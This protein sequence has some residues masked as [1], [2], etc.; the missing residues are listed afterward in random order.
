MQ[1]TH[2]L[3]NNNNISN[4]KYLSEKNNV[5]IA[6]PNVYKILCEYTSK[7]GWKRVIFDHPEKYYAHITRSIV[8]CFLWIYTKDSLELVNHFYERK[9]KK[10]NFIYDLLVYSDCNTI[11]D[12][13]YNQLIIR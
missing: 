8:S 12:K 7:Y 6:N 9:N 1:I 13:K 10:N 3:L 4:L 5:L 11:L 2:T